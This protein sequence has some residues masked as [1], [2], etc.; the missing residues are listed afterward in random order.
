MTFALSRSLLAIFLLSSLFLLLLSSQFGSTELLL[1]NAAWMSIVAEFSEYLLEYAFL[2]SL[3]LLSL[4]SDLIARFARWLFIPVVLLI[5]VLQTISLWFS[6]QSV[7]PLMIDNL[8]AVNT[9][10]SQSSIFEAAAICALIIAGYFLTRFLLK[11]LSAAGDVELNMAVAVLVVFS[12]LAVFFSTDLDENINRRASPIHSAAS[13]A[14]FY[15]GSENVDRKAPGFQSDA[16]KKLSSFGFR[17][18]PNAQYPLQKATFYESP[19][20][21]EYDSSRSS[22]NVIAFFVEA[23]S[24][25]KL[26]AYGASFKNLT[27][28]IDRF[29]AKSMRVDN[30]FNHTQSTFRGIKGQLC[31]SYPVHTTKPKQW[32]NP[33]F[34]PP[35][36]RYKCLPHH[37][38]DA[39]YK[40]VFLG[41]DEHDHMH[42]A[43]QTRSVGFSHNYYREEIKR[44]YLRQQ[45]FYGPFLTDV[46]L[47]E[48]LEG[49][50]K[51]EPGDKPL[52]I[53][54]Y[55]KDGHVGQDS[56][57]DGTKYGDGGNRI[58]NTVHTFDKA[59]G[60]F[61]DTFVKSERYEDTIIVLTSDHAHWPE[62][63][64]INIAGSDFNQTP[65]D[66]IALVIHSPMI[67][68]PSVFDAENATSL[69]FA[70][71]LAHLLNVDSVTNY[72][73]GRSLFDTRIAT[74]SVAW[75]NNAIFSIDGNGDVQRMNVQNDL[76]SNLASA[77]AAI[78]LTHRLELTDTIQPATQP[79]SR[80]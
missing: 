27:P 34:K 3:V 60:E 48:A 47:F 53:A 54:G 19:L 11:R 7:S 24:A 13:L 28:N 1:G 50:L 62:R 72:F 14:A 17:L 64:Y 59:F 46:Q 61:W 2:I 56:K 58:L 79:V 35:S 80:Q 32:A 5:W 21:F 31:S 71:S 57:P 63:P 36:V 42:F 23:L 8:G 25:R 70:P 26:P 40:T 22:P 18:A 73:L 30:Y 76:P 55:F 74:Q 4:R 33:D 68:T 49:M 15:M 45:D 51:E 38:N 29:A 44:K 65:V 39:G 41:P 75:F 9:I 67:N 52:F 16:S 10:V 20:P 6:N 78:S 43:Y 12:L 66:R 77:W 37:L 69:A